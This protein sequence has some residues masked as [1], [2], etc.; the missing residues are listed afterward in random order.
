[1]TIKERAFKALNLQDYNSHNT[2]EYSGDWKGS[3]PFDRQYILRCLIKKPFEN[4][5]LSDDLIWCSELIWKTEQNQKRLGIR[6]P[7]CYITVRHGL[8]ESVTDDEW[9]VDGFS[10][11]ITHLPEQNYAWSNVCSTEYIVKPIEFPDDF[12]PLKHNIHLFF[13]DSITSEDKIHRMVQNSIYCFDPYIIHRHPQ[14]PAGLVRTFVR[15][16]YTP[17][18][19]IDK[20]NTQNPLLPTFATRDAVKDFRQSLVRYEKTT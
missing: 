5:Q 10:Q 11:T 15:V 4:F 17:I 16:S 14:V 1:M 18:E 9:H 19:I 2:P 13:Q 7:F 12:D 6:Q 8:V 3:C 20:T